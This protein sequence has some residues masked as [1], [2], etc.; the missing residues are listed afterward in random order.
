VSCLVN[1]VAC[2]FCHELFTKGEAD[3]CPACGLLLTDMTKLPL[4]DDARAEDDFGIPTQPHLE[5][6]PISYIGRGKGI[7]LV[8]SLLGMIAFFGPWVNQTS[9]E[10]AIRSGGDLARRIGWIWGAFVGWLVL[11][12]TVLSRRSIDKMR[13]ARVAAAFLC[14]VPAVTA[15]ILWL[16]PP[17]GGRIPL[18]FDWGWGLYA[19]LA[20]GLV[21]TVVA[22]R[23][24]GRVDDIRVTRGRVAGSGEAL[25]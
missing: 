17:R 8:A 5:T 16:R 21:A 25:H 4:S 20:L 1:L 15:S 3:V 19:T 2:P 24:G 11:F 10:I 22:A 14:A 13:G 9:P 23:F 6:L 12:P 18:R 7:L